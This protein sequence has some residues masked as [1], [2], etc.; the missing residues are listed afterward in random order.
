MKLRLLYRRIIFHSSILFRLLHRT[1]IFHGSILFKNNLLCC[2]PYA[3]F[4]LCPFS[5]CH[6]SRLIRM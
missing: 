3:L 2:T 4:P 6:T 5:H 1:I